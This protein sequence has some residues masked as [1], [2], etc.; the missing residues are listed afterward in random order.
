[1]TERINAVV[2]DFDGTLGD[3]REK[4]LQVTRRI[5]ERVTGRSH[6]EF[7][8]LRTLEDYAS[9]S[10]RSV[11]WRQFY[12]QEFGLTEDETDEA[13]RLWTEYQLNDGHPTPMYTSRGLR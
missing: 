13:G 12:R 1:M 7:P 11:N 9:A 10:R 8:V 4:N 3:T 5:V 2:W 6:V